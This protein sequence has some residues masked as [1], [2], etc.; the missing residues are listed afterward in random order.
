MKRKTFIKLST[1]LM[2]TPLLSSLEAFAQPERL[3]NWSGNLTYST[4]NVFY[5][6]S[7]AEVQQQVKKLNKLKGLGTRHCFNT[8]ADSKDNLVSSKNLN[9]V[10]SLDKKAHTVTVEG[11]IKYGELAPYLHEQ[12]VAL[13]NLAS[14][15]HISVAG[16]CTTATHGSGI[17]NGNLASAVTGLEMVIADGSV[18]HLSKATDA[19]KLNAV[20]VGLGAIGIITKVT[21]QVQPTFMMRQRVFTDMPMAQVKQHFEKI[22]SA[23]Y[24]VSLFTDWQKD[25]INEVWIKSK[26]GVDKDE[27]S[28]EFYGAKAATKNLHPI[29][30]LSAENCTEQMGVPGPWY[31]R[32]PHFK[33]GFTPSSGKE[34]QSEFFVPLRH[35]VEAIAAVARLGKQI[36]PHLFITEIRTIA[37]DNLWMSPCHNQTSVAIH[38]TWKQETAAVLKLLPLIEKELSPFNARPHWGKIFTMAPKI[39]ESRYE[40][41]NDFKKI[42]AEYDPH[43]KF[44]N[45]FLNHELYNI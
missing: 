37:A 44:R 31:E 24:S 32:L 8:I 25:S 28:A 18:V 27:N 29:I 1:T 23:G 42:V 17:K 13:H 30:A 21:L 35:A 36:G 4:D 11:G 2:A 19:E 16:S 6:K 15:P 34:L 41:L 20:V 5:P 3:K 7:V 40:K 38:F 45:G 26:I 22:V 43:G 39:L 9:K 14:L 12:G 33:M 10:V